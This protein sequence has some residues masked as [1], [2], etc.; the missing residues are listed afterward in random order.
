MKINIG[1]IGLGPMG[2]R[3]YAACLKIKSSNILLCDLNF[4]R[5]KNL[6]AKKKYIHWQKLINNEKIDL[7]IVSS[8]GD[9]HYEIL[10]FA[11]EKKIKKIL[12]EKPLTNSI[13]KANE[14]VFLA[15]NNK[16]LI[17]INHIRRWSNSYKK[18][19][20]LINND[21]LGHIKN[22]YFEM[23]GGQLASNG[24]HL[25]DLARLLTSSEP[26]EIIAFIDKRN[27]PNP[28]GK[29]FSDP[30]GYGILKMKDNTRVFFDMSEDYGTPGLIKVLCVYGT[31]IIDE[32]SKTWRIYGRKTK[33]RS[34]SLTKRPPLKK[35][36]FSGE[37]RINM[38]KSSYSA[39]INLIKAKNSLDL[40]CNLFDGY[41]SLMIA[42]GAHLSSYK[43]KKITFPL[44]N[45]LIVKKVF[46]F[47]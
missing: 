8:N 35:I 26:K 45:R 15:K 33:D 19:K 5:I 7:L 39:I 18:L 17:A 42:I 14:L 21:T 31:I 13:D 27:T 20:K 9:T 1:I 25:F 24:G 47:T 41:Q 23:G 29:K 36:P 16:T 2:Y 40:K 6:H 22:I 10:K 32:I 4:D 12:C 37:G 46:R 34:L 3:H 43:N 30:G 11:I 44:K 28:R 38:I